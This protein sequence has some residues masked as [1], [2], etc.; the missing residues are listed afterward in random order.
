MQEVGETRVRHLTNSFGAPVARSA[1]HKIRFAFIQ[2]IDTLLK[3][4]VV[5]MD[6]YS[7]AQMPFCKFFGSAHIQHH[8]LGKALVE[9]GWS[10]V[11]AGLAAGCTACAQQDNNDCK[12]LERCF[13]KPKITTLLGNSVPTKKAS[14]RKPAGD[15]WEEDLACV[16]GRKQKTPRLAGLSFDNNKRLG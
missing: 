10:E 3:I 14:L 1:V 12:Q 16:W 11:M 9:F 2:A 4:R 8:P 15:W 5:N 7:P 6:I 13:H